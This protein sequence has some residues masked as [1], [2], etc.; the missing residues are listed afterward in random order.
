MQMICIGIGSVSV[1]RHATNVKPMAL[2]PWGDTDEYANTA[3]ETRLFQTA[4]TFESNKVD[5]QMDLLARCAVGGGGASA[6]S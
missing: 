3:D 1:L 2:G 6:G 5:D 4:K